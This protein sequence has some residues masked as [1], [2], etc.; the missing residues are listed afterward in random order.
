MKNRKLLLLNFIKEKPTISPAHLQRDMYLLQ[1]KTDNR[2][3][4]FE[5]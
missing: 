5:L 4:R 2:F 1:E 3:Y